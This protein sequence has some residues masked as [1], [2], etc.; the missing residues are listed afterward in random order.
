MFINA[1]V[2][3]KCTLLVFLDA[4]GAYCALLVQLNLPPVG[5]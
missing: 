3:A 5:N 1:F 4:E 2:N